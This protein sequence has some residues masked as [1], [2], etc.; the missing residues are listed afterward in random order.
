MSDLLFD[1]TYINIAGWTLVHFLWQASLIGVGVWIAN[2]LLRHHEAV[3]R[4]GIACVGLA[5]MFW[6]ALGT[7][8]SLSFTSTSFVPVSLPVSW[9]QS[10]LSWIYLAW[11]MGVT[12]LTLRLVGGWLLVYR[13]KCLADPVH[14]GLR[15]RVESLRQNLGIRHQV[16]VLRSALVR[17]PMVVGWF[18]PVVLIP[19]SLVTGIPAAELE[20]LL[21]HEL[22]HIRRYDYLVN[23]LQAFVETVFF[24]HPMVWW[25][26]KRIRVEREHCCDDLALTAADKLTYTKALLELEEHK[27]AGL[28]FSYSGVRADGGHLVSRIRRLA[29]PTESAG[30]PVVKLMSGAAVAAMIIGSIQ[31]GDAGRVV[32]MSPQSIEPLAVSVRIFQD[33]REGISGVEAAQSRA[34]ISRV[35]DPITN[36]PSQVASLETPVKVARIVVDDQDS[37]PSETRTTRVT[38]P[39]PPVARSH[40]G[41]VRSS[42]R[43]PAFVTQSSDPRGSPNSFSNGRLALGLSGGVIQSSTVGPLSPNLE[44]RTLWV[45]GPITQLEAGVGFSVYLHENIYA[46]TDTDGFQVQMATNYEQQLQ[47]SLGIRRSFSD[48]RLA[49]FYYGL[50]GGL[51][52]LP[53]NR[54]IGDADK[55][56]DDYESKTGYFFLP[57]LG[58]VTGTRSSVGWDLSAGLSFSRANDV[59]FVQPVVSMGVNFWR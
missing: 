12:G 59:A 2:R 52:R 3:W 26:S 28:T 58:Y 11:M 54:L 57:K 35:S 49:G 20:A 5:A 27:G 38:E 32:A 16:Q 48:Q 41:G 51:M 23:G 34:S 17:V 50:A 6:A 30:N 7:A 47:L 24:F 43:L 40:G 31:V 25:V 33:V 15:E 22:S 1:P 53:I 29:T 42:E 8:Y 10:Q 19:G 18:K 56:R 55:M 21:A 45:L 39:A 46:Y 4:Y 44:L 13:I 36:P 37:G 14:N 9:I